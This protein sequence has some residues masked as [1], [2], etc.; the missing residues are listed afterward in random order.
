MWQC[1]TS[2]YGTNACET[3]CLWKTCKAQPTAYCVWI[4][5]WS[6]EVCFAT[7]EA[8]E[9][10]KAEVGSKAQCFAAAPEYNP[11]R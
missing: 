2:E 8:C 4:P 7:V 3:T 5:A 10:I 9:A 6:R 1:Q 11:G